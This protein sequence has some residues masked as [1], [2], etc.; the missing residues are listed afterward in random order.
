MNLLWNFD[1]ILTKVEKHFSSSMLPTICTPTNLIS[2]TC[3]KK[4]KT[5]IWDIVTRHHIMGR[6]LMLKGGATHVAFDFISELEH[7]LL[8]III[9]SILE[10]QRP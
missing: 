7:A 5:R 6:G 4:L 10:I 2:L 8:T 3:S 1:F 9:T